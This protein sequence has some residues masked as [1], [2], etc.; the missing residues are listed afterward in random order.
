MSDTS[1]RK[2][3][4]KVYMTKK[5][6]ERWHRTITTKNSLIYMVNSFSN[7]RHVLRSFTQIH[8]H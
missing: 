1:K 8:V 4:R 3:L 7:S 2:F 5:K 6:C